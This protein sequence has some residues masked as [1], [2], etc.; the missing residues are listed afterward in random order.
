MIIKIIKKKK[1]YKHSKTY[2]NEY[3]MLRCIIYKYKRTYIYGYP[4][5]KY[6]EKKKTS[7]LI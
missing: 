3:N 4:R 7:E 6:D 1:N 2:Y 5:I